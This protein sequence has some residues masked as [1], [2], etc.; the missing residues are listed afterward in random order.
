MGG[1]LDLSEEERELEVQREG[2]CNP[3]GV[4]HVFAQ[5]KHTGTR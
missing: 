1:Y 3:G 5:G 4:C 2:R